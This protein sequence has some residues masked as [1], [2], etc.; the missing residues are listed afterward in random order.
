VV[1]GVSGILITG[2]SGQVA[3]SLGRLAAGRAVVVG[4]PAFDFDVPETIE[5]ALGAARP[6]LVI[7][8]A[9]WTA[10]DA[11]EGDEAGAYRANTAGPGRIA[12]W[13]QANGARL[14]HISTD[15]VFDGDKGAPYVEDDVPAPTGVY[16]A[17]KLAGEREVM[18]ACPGA[19]VLRTSWVYAEQGKNFLRTMLGA[20]RKV[21]RLRVVGDQIGCPTNA[22]DLAAAILAVGEQMMGAPTGLGGVFHAAGSGWTSWHGFATEIFTQ[23]GPLG[24]PAPVVDAI[25]T[26]DWPTPARRPADSRLDCARLRD[27]FGQILPEW[28]ESLARAVASICYAEAGT[29]G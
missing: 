18:T 20:A 8:A 29:A 19:V 16:G 24:W 22:D 9:A 15:Y 7:N 14:I 25:T 6:E 5:A 10:V 12:A 11:A 3:R 23:A 4:R 2:G 17:T 13:C 21:D 27:V 1:F 28:R 26:A